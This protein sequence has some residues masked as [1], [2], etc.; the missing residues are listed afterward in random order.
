MTRMNSG[1]SSGF[2]FNIPDIQLK[3]PVTSELI[4]FNRVTYI[5]RFSVLYIFEMIGLTG[6]VHEIASAKD[7]ID[8]GQLVPMKIKA[9][10]AQGLMF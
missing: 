1:C 10:M 2:C 9:L 4:H 7:L 6:P 8:A 5:E 3:V